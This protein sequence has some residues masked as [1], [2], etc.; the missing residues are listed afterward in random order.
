[1]TPSDF[2][3]RYLRARFFIILS[4]CLLSQLARGQ[5]FSLSGWDL[6]AQAGVQL[7]ISTHFQRIGIYGGL[8]HIHNRLQLNQEARITFNLKTP[9]PPGSHW[10]CILSQG[11]SYGYGRGYF[12]FRNYSHPFYTNV[13]NQTFYDNSV[14]FAYNV[15]LNRIGTMQTTGTIQLGFGPFSLITENDILARPAVDRFRTGAIL[16]QYQH[17][18]QAQF[19]INCTAWTGKFGR[20]RMFR[21][22]SWCYMDTIGGKFTAYSHGLLSAQAKFILPYSHITQVSAGIDAEQVRNYIQNE[23]LHDLFWRKNCY[24]PMID[25]EGKIYLYPETQKIKRPQVYSGIQLNP[26]L[27]Y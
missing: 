23:F 11:I 12:R 6:H 15:Y 22:S 18:N 24:M 25:Q 17:L 3:S 10:E 14:G 21:D 4:C 20:K 26:P 16:L 19:G 2:S 27:F 13:S 9:G 8:Y 7:S 1:M 5:R